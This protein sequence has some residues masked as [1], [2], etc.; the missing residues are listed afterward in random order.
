MVSFLVKEQKY[1]DRVGLIERLC[2][3]QLFT[4]ELQWRKCF[5]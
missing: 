2:F 1:A 4:A 3:K 5:Y